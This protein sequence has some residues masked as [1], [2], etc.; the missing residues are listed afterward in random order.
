MAPGSGV[1]GVARSQ[2]D[3]RNRSTVTPVFRNACLMVLAAVSAVV[4]GDPSAPQPPADSAQNEAGSPQY[5]PSFAP[6]PPGSPDATPSKG[7]KA[8]QAPKAPRVSPKA[9]LLPPITSPPADSKTSS[10]PASHSGLSSGK[11]SP[12]DD[13][14]L[15]SLLDPPPQ[16]DAA[17]QTPPAAHKTSNRSPTPAVLP[18]E[19]T[20]EVV[21]GQPRLLVFPD[22]PERISLTVDE[23]DPVASLKEVPHHDREWY[24][25]GKKPGTAFLDVRLPDSA[26]SSPR[27]VLHYLVRVRRDPDNKEV[28]EGVYR[29]LER[30]I[31]RSFPGSAVHLTRVDDK[32]IVSGQRAQHFRG[33]AHTEA[34]L[35]ASAGRSTGPGA[36]DAGERFGP[37]G[38]TVAAIRSRQLREGRRAEG[39]QPAA[40]PRRTANHASRRG[41]GSE[42]GGGAQSR[43]RF[44]H[45][46]KTG[47]GPRLQSGER[48]QRVHAGGQRLDSPSPPHLAGTPLLRKRWPSRR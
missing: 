36:R 38:F 26:N 32:L 17:R 11:S 27:R 46:R 12:G 19:S 30:E 22:V 15:P 40:H 14:K 39:G 44:R 9:V 48:Q 37:R 16:L 18:S 42:Q 29:T 45:R 8:P 7:D 6:A 35:R 21:I 43:T 2:V 4:A 25:F 10:A 5:L 33:D 47:D 13:K 41:H 1:C 23:A 31:N 34:R 28:L 20:L 24:V 3:S